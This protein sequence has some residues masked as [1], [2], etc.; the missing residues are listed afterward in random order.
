MHFSTILSQFSKIFWALFPPPGG[1]L[2]SIFEF[3]FSR[4]LSPYFFPNF[5]HFLNFLLQ[6]IHVLIIGTHLLLTWVTNLQPVTLTWPTFFTTP[7]TSPP[8]SPLHHEA[9]EPNLHRHPDAVQS[10]WWAEGDH[11]LV[12]LLRFSW[13]F[14]FIFSLSTSL[15]FHSHRQKSKEVRSGDLSGH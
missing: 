14:P 7:S 6:G 3:P 2:P 1:L 11:I 8:R 10:P 5:R 13:R 4:S 15:F 12:S 9:V